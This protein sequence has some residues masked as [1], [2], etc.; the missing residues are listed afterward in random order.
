MDRLLKR[1]AAAVTAGLIMIS[2]G[3]GAY[4]EDDVSDDPYADLVLPSGMTAS[5]VINEINEMGRRNHDDPDHISA[6]VG[7]FCGNDVIHTGYYG[8]TDLE[9]RIPEDE[10]TV[11]EWGSI[12]KTLVWVSVMQL[13]EQGKL[14]LDRDVREYLPDGFFRKLSY[15]DPIT[16]M[17]LM[18]HN[19]GWQ[20]TM[21]PIWKTDGDTILP[22][23]DELQ[24]IEPAQIHRPG[25][26][27]AYSNYGAAVAGYVVECV[28]GMDYCEYVHKNILEPLG[29][30]HTAIYS[31]HSDN[32]YVY[33]K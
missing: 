33:E 31:D 27:T 11:Y 15:D 12:S 19:A 14:D 32:A 16:M 10:G 18:D 30:E 17:N 3:I 22:L 8:Y 5:K 20:E 25:E 13:M 29:M 7:I 26:V 2:S 9:N 6:A 23:K 1:A 21:R 28:S 4:A 24:A